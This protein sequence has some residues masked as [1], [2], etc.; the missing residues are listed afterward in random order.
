MVLRVIPGVFDAD[1]WYFAIF[2]A[3]S[4]VSQASAMAILELC[5]GVDFAD[6][7]E[8]FQTHIYLQKLASIQPRTSPPK[9]ADTNTIP[10]TP[11]S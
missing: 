3:S 7:C 6:L 11:G 5:K 1:S 10:S 8:T 2:T 9:F 4:A